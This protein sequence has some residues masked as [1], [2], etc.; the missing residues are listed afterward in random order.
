MPAFVEPSS[1][2]NFGKLLR[3]HDSCAVRELANDNNCHSRQSSSPVRGN[4]S[5]KQCAGD[6]FAVVAA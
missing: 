6:E 4:N 5:T 1:Y 3:G 2:D